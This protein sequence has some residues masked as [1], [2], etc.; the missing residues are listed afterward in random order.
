MQLSSP[1]SAVHPGDSGK[2]LPEFLIRKIKTQLVQIRVFLLIKVED[3]TL[4]FVSLYLR[5]SMMDD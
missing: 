1:I 3:Y 4:N 5:I 2:S